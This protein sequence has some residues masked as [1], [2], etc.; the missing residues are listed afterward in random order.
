MA[1]YYACSP[2]GNDVNPAPRRSRGRRCEGLRDGGAGETRLTWAGT[3][4]QTLRPGKSGETEAGAVR[5]LLRAEQVVLSGAD[6]LAGLG[7]STAG[8]STSYRRT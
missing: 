3:Y 4:R 5:N 2:K 8:T 1:A 6:T 7:S